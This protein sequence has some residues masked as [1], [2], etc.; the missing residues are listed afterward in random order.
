[1][2]TAIG[3]RLKEERQRVGLTI[4]ALAKAGEASKRSQI[5]WEKAGSATPNAYTLERYAKAGIDILYVVTGQRTA[6]HGP[7][8]AI[9]GDDNFVMV[10]RYDLAASAGAGYVVQSNE[11]I[12]DYLAFK[13]EWV[14]NSLGIPQKDLAL[15]SVKG[16]SMQPT[17]SDGD[18]VLIDTSRKVVEDSGVYVIRLA[19]VLVVKR[20]QRHLDGSLT[21]TSDNP[22]YQPEHVSARHD[23]TVL[24]VGRVVWTGRRL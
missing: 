11:Q 9:L 17:L 13:A 12:V 20:V 16:D 3:Q 22:K 19:E 15:I 10:P 23:T 4:D 6:S 2:V 5:E 8:V 1:M 24:V 21:V 18:L 14:R 7:S